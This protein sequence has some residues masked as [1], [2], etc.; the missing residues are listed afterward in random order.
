MSPSRCLSHPIYRLK[1]READ[2]QADFKQ[3]RQTTRHAELVNECF[4]RQV[5]K[6]AGSLKKTEHNFHR[7]QSGRR[8]CLPSALV[9]VM[10]VAVDAAVVIEVLLRRRLLLRLPP[11]PPPPPPQ[12][13]LP[14][15][16]P[17]PLHGQNNTAQKLLYRTSDA[18]SKKQMHLRLGYI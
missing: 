6:H 3:N 5:D 18:K 11:S 14:L 2:R 16:L 17:P 15:L 8:C 9:V 7:S 12:Q 10:V 13:L 1:G 4:D